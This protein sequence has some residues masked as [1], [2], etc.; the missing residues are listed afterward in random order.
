MDV[1]LLSPVDLMEQL[2]AISGRL[3]KT[4][5]LPVNNVKEDVKNIYKLVYIKARVTSNYFLFEVHIPLTSDENFS[6]Y[7]ATPLPVKTDAGTSI[8]QIQ[9]QYIAVNFQKNIY[10]SPYENELKLCTM[11]KQRNYICNKNMPVFNLQSKNAPCEAKLLSHT[12]STPCDVK[13]TSCSDAWIELHTR[14]TW[15]AVCCGTCTL[16]TIC[17]ND[18]ASYTMTSSAIVTL[19]Q[20]CM[21]QSSDFTIYSHNEYNSNLK[22]QLNIPLLNSTVNNIVNLTHHN[23]PW[24]VLHNTYEREMQDIDKRLTSQKEREVLPTTISSHDVHQ[25]VICYILLGTA[26]FIATVWI[27]RKCYPLNCAKNRNKQSGAH[28]E[29]IELQYTKPERAAQSAPTP[30]PPR[31]RAVHPHSHPTTT[32]KAED[33]FAFNFDD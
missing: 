18:V 9:S 12:I 31:P 25:Y 15:L 24:Q 16:R 11:L 17:D 29:D 2:N 22:I 32:T 4:L 1:H 13:K 33:N 26:I 5:T 6:L 8:I 27:V 23:V 3:P 28:H 10:I 14:N 30:P 19:T 20:G 21:L 7:K